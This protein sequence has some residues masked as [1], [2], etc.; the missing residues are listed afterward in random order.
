LTLC[1]CATA[2][3]VSDL[4]EVSAAPTHQPHERRLPAGVTERT[5]IGIGTP[6]AL[7]APVVK[8]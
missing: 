4:P 1:I 2:I 7:P 8:A 5:V 3:A 6:G